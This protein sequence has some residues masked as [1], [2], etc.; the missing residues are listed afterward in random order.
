MT[1]WAGFSSK[2]NRDV[3]VLFRCPFCAWF[4]V[5]FCPKGDQ[6][7]WFFV[8]SKSRRYRIVAGL[9][10]DVFEYDFR[11]DYGRAHG[12]RGCIRFRVIGY[13]NCVIP[14][15]L[16]A[17]LPLISDLR[18]HPVTHRCFLTYRPVTNL[19]PSFDSHAVILSP[20]GASTLPSC[21]PH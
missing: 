20:S 16:P 14:A 11:L 13:Q 12:K 10:R 1:T 2:A 4:F 8:E 6:L 18:Y 9:L 21:S 7:G 17:T 3:T 15:W 19:F 5:V